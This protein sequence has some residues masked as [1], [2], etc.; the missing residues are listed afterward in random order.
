MDQNLVRRLSKIHFMEIE[1]DILRKSLISLNQRK[2]ELEQ[3]YTDSAAEVEQLKQ[4]QDL[5]KI[6]ERMAKLTKR[7]HDL[8]IKVND[9]KQK[10][11]EALSNHSKSAKDLVERK[12]RFLEEL[13]IL[14]PN[15]D[16]IY[17]AKE[18]WMDEVDLLTA[19]HKQKRDDLNDHLA[20]Y[21]GVANQLTINLQLIE[22]GIGY[23]SANQDDVNIAETIERAKEALQD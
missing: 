8:E 12:Q 14:L 17:K 11:R 7:F 20:K 22:E 5:S 18:F 6:E 1:K 3:E 2:D 4:N 21:E 23:N 10:A 15:E 9:C 13:S 16:F 19:W